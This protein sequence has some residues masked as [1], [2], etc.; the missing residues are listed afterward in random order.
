LVIGAT[1][2]PD[3]P[4]SLFAN[5]LQHSLSPTSIP[6]YVRE[7]LVLANWASTDS[8]SLRNQWHLLAPP[9]Q[10]RHLIRE[11]LTAGADC[12]VSTRPDTA[13]L[14]ITYVERG[15]G[16]R[17]NVR[18]LLAALKRFYEVLIARG[19]YLHQNPLVQEEAA[20]IQERVRRAYREA[21]RS[22]EGRF[23]MP[24]VSGVDPAFD[25]LRFSQNYF[26]SIRDEWVPKTIDDPDFP[27][28]IY[29]AGKAFGWKLRE[30]CIA[31]TLFE[32]GARISEVCSLS[33]ADW[34]VSRFMARFASVDKGSHGR[35]TKFL[36]VSAP[37][38][39][40]YRM[41]FNER[42]AVALTI[43][44]KVQSIGQLEVLL[45][46]DSHQLQRVPIFLTSRGTAMSAQLF[47]DHYWR[48]ALR[49]GGID[50][51]PHAARHWFVT[52]A[53]RN[54]E[55]QCHDE[56]ELQRR[57][58]ELV[59]Y[60]GWRSGERTMRVYEHLQRRERF[61]VQLNHIHREMGQRERQYLKSVSSPAPPAAHMQAGRDLAFLLGEDNDD[62]TRSPC[63]P[64]GRD[65]SGMATVQGS[66]NETDCDAL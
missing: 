39:K 59:Q 42:R 44:P 40:M 36:M 60:M 24:G 51:D 21:V 34:S 62:V 2:I 1:G 17:V 18:T 6:V 63:T 20:A 9:E 23:P 53:L 57:K 10:V 52:N 32:S 47:R 35:R 58:S 14:M 66:S 27:N 11:Y 49:K 28:L 61:W 55:A 8:V 65:R 37:T 56:G 29:A 33:A 43:T 7:I 12:K 50:A 15:S 45:K 46:S 19:L 3:A 16:T 4:L 5:E 54:I 26:R 38:A 48:P 41:Y 22:A 31:R 13:G 64:P 25:R 30:L